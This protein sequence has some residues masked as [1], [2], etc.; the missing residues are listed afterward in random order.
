VAIVE[1]RAM[2]ETGCL[3]SRGSAGG[4]LDVHNVVIGEVLRRKRGRRR[5]VDQVQEGSNRSE[6]SGLNATRGVVDQDHMLEAG[7]MGGFD[8]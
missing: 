3:G 6:R 5:A 4:E 1:N 8:T 7:N 2:R